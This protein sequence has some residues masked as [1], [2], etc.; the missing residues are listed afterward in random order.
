MRLRGRRAGVALVLAGAALAIGCLDPGEP[1]EAPA[2]IAWVAYPETVRTGETFSLEFAGPI[3]PNSCG[4]LDTATVALADS[5]L[6]LDVRRSVFLDA[7]CSDDRRS[8]YQVRP[9]RLERAG[10]Y[11]IRAR[12]GGDLGTLVAVDSGRFSPMTTRGAG[13][14]R[15]GG[16]CVF[17]GPGWATNQRPFAL[18][19]LPERLRR[20]AGTDTLV[21]VE[22]QLVGYSLCGGFGSRPS[23]RV[24]TARAT[25]RTGAD[26]YPEP[27]EPDAGRPTERGAEH[28]REWGDEP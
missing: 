20:L 12:G 9:L 3:S 10:R 21:H 14:L 26:W 19:N 8:F 25:G 22:G 28:E 11:H 27:P 5:V 6:Q 2:R 17:L 7:M 4:R 15:A 18:R 24:D 13:T 16:G 1:T 23:I